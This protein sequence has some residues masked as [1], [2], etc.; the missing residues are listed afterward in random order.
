MR[1]ALFRTEAGRPGEIGLL[2]FRLF[3]AFVLIYGTMDNVFSHERMLEF[4]DFLAGNGFPFPLLSARVSAYA[5]FVCGILIG[6]GLLTRPAAAVVV[7][8]FAVALVMVHRDLPFSANISPL[9]M[10]FGGLLFL[11]YGAGR[12]SLDAR[13]GGSLEPA[14]PNVYLAGSP[15]R[16]R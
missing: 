9:A 8:N 6:V 12:F 14:G 10:F 2:L 4:R 16:G 3:L 5:Q 15:G 7:V 1:S 11:L 13:V